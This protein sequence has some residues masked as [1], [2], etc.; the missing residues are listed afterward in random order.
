MKTIDKLESGCLNFIELYEDIISYELMPEAIL[1][2]LN[3]FYKEQYEM[4]KEMMET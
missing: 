4:I 2:M 3:D 1:K